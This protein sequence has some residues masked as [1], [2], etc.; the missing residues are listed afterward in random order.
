LKTTKARWTAEGPSLSYEDVDVSLI[1]PRPR[2][3]DV[4]K[5]AS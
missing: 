2:K 1:K 5:S 3:Y 4:D